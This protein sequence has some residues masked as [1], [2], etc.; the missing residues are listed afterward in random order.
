MSRIDCVKIDTSPRCLANPFHDSLTNFKWVFFRNDFKFLQKMVVIIDDSVEVWNDIGNLVKVNP[1]KFFTNHFEFKQTNDSLL[2]HLSRVLNGI[3]NKFYCDYDLN[4]FTSLSSNNVVIPDVREVISHSK[5]NVLKNCVVM[6]GQRRQDKHVE[7]AVVF[8][9][10]VLDTLLNHDRIGEV[11][12]FIIDRSD[13]KLH[14]YAETNKRIKTV[15]YGWLFNSIVKW[16]RETET[17][18]NFVKHC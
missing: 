6:F 12:H 17:E 3:H 4:V 7:A 15:T 14:A 9:C 2:N 13:I 8:G 11:T 10:V 18:H 16:K 5:L 1:Y